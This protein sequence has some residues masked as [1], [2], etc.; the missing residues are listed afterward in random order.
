VRLRLAFASLVAA[1]LAAPAAL[2]RVPTV[3]VETGF[4]MPS[5]NIVCNAGRVPGDGRGIDCTV[6]SARSSRGQKVWFTGERGR[7]SVG[8]VVGDPQTEGLAT[9]RYGR[10]WRWHGIRCT[11][12]R[13]GLTC[14]NRN[15]HGFFLSRERQRLF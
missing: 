14:T 8:F 10:T 12:R 15:G 7:A 5:N 1:A 11:S 9:L 3:I 13:A 4:W 2:A 6:L